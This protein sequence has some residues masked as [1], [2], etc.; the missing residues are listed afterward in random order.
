MVNVGTSFVAVELAVLAEEV[1][2]V[3]TINIVCD[4]L[5]VKRRWK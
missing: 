3:I 1:W 4:G 2:D 5:C